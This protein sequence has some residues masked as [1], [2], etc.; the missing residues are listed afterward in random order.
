MTKDGQWRVRMSVFELVADLAII[1]GKEI[2]SKQLQNIFMGYLTNTAASVRQMGITKSAVLAQAFKQDWIMADYIPTVNNHFN[3]D[4]KGYNYRMCCLSSMA[5][6]MPFIMK[7]QI[8]QQIIPMFVKASK[9]EIPNV[10]FCVS[11]IIH[12]QRQFIEPNVYNNQL[13]V[14]L[15]EMSNDPD[16]DVSHFAQVALQTSA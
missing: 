11:K 12:Q 1:Y 6:V 3:V 9:D 2:Y 7:D 5:A 10:K 8:T 15:K 14:V 13:V 4:K 16:K